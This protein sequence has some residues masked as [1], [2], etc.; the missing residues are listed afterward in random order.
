VPYKPKKHLTINIGGVRDGD[1]VFVM[2]Y[3]GSTTR[4]RESQSIEFAEK[5][6]FPFLAAYLEARSN[7]LRKV[8]ETDDE[9]RIRYQSDIA[10][11][12]NYNKVY[13]GSSLALRRADTVAD[14][15]AEEAKFT[16]W[17]NA[18]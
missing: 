2:G 3:P 18:N 7:A 8:G 11:L 5:A 13:E 16:I 10:N 12:D 9:K 4:Y 1:F 15:R 17:V 6:N 14:R